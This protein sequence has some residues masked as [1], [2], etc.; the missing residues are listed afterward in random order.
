M[1]GVLMWHVGDSQGA[2]MT[3]EEVTATTEPIRNDGES[4]EQSHAPGWNEFDSDESGELHGLAPRLAGSDTIDTEKYRPWWAG[5]AD[6]NYNSPI[7]DQVASSGTA[8]AREMAGQQ[9]HG[10][11]QYA[12]GIEPVIREGAEYGNDYFTT[13]PAVIQE[14]AGD[15]MTP[16]NDDAWANA[17]G[18][19]NAT[20]NSR[21]AFNDSLFADFIGS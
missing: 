20:A 12:L 16:L 18:Q 15:Y 10:S 19:A 2:A 3:E 13:N 5:L 14:G 1:S 4:A 7:D 6:V 21:Q 9:G 17:L 8:A 11:M